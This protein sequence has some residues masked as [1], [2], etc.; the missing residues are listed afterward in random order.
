MMIMIRKKIR[1]WV[2]V[3]S[4]KFIVNVK[5]MIMKSPIN[6]E[7]NK[8]FWFQTLFSVMIGFRYSTSFFIW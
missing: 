4:T 5:I 8:W 7:I 2:R 3:I 1:T 6:N